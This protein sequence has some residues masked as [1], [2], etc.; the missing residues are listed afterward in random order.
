[1][2]L[3]HAT[4]QAIATGYTAAWN[5]GS[6]LAV[7]G[8]YAADGQIV[9][10]RGPPWL[11]RAGVAAMAQGF[12]ADVPDLQ[13]SC[14]GI[15]LM[16][17]HMVYLWTFVGHHAGTK[18]PLRISGCEEWDLDA[19]GLVQASRGWFDGDLYARQIAGG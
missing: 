15:R 3:E 4:V 8:Y 14:D 19:A 17:D 2:A 1:M 16:G 13:L 12:Y 7:A 18:N 6:A 5:S 10:N 11:G 9:I